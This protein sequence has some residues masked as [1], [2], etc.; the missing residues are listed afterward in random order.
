LLEN[1]QF[2]QFAEIL[3]SRD[4]TSVAETF[5]AWVQQACQATR[6]V[7]LLREPTTGEFTCRAHRGL[8]SALLP[9][10]RFSQLAPLCRW[11]ASAGYVLVKDD[12]AQS[13]ADVMRG[14]DL[15][16]AIVAIPMMCDGQ[17]TGILGLGP[18][19]VGQQY[20]AVELESLFALG[21]QI[22]IIVHHHR[23]Q[24][25]MQAQQEVTA[26]MLGVMPI[27]T[28][29]LG[30]D[31]RVTFANTAAA[32][33]LGLQRS[34]LHGVDLR[35]LPS[36]LGDIAYEARCTEV[37]VPRRELTL[38]VTGHPVAVTGLSLKTTPRSALILLEDLLPQHQLEDEK[39]RRQD[40]EVA[41]NL[42]HYVAHELRNPLVALATFSNMVTS[43]ADDEDF[44][45]FCD[46]VLRDE[47][48]RI[49]LFIE[50]L[51]ILSQ[52]ADFH[53]AEL[54]LGTVFN[55]ITTSCDLQRVRIVGLPKTSLPL[56]GD[57]HRLEIAIACILR[58]Y[59]RLA[60]DDTVID[61]SIEAGDSVATIT[62]QAEVNSDVPLE[63]LM[64]PWEQLIGEENQDIDLGL[65]TAKYIFEQHHGMLTVN[66]T[67]RML[68][69]ICQLPLSSR[70]LER[71][72]VTHGSS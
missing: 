68:T 36:P 35:A 16:Q 11:L 59:S 2:R 14:L 19:V 24:R 31:D 32:N 25:T 30:A 43:H 37:D 28:V 10:C 15:M 71:E 42:V 23:V 26:H 60:A 50:Q 52:S 22:A 63:C 69:S 33:I 20:S 6:V 45:E 67:A 18:R 57:E 44:H 41:T 40:L 62:L 70:Q 8:S 29:V 38:P 72:G 58:T 54:A 61:V 56:Y 9:S 13:S 46:T 47:I 12:A 17:L 49:N 48:N 64:N 66:R 27:G 4:E 39:R 51:I 53:F 7:M 21:A 65:A 1:G 3:S 5:V 55:R 34:D